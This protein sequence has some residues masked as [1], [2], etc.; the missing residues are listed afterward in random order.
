MTN[1]KI[2]RSR[3]FRIHL[4]RIALHIPSGDEEGMTTRVVRRSWHVARR[5][6]IVTLLSFMRRDSSKTV[7]TC[8]PLSAYRRITENAIV[9]YHGNN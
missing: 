2:K 4:F 3:I 9:F 5:L 1:L 6:H 8:K 7:V